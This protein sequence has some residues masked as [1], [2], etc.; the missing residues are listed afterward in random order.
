MFNQVLDPNYF[1]NFSKGHFPELLG[2]VIKQVEEGKMIAEMP[3]KKTLFAPN[4]FLHA[5]SIVAFADT[6]AGY[7][8]IAHLPEKGK[9]FTTLELKSNFTGAI[10]EGNLECECSAEH[11]GRTTQVWRVIIRNQQTKKKT[12]VFSCTQLILY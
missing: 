1:N 2:I 5:G 11:L 8:T 7:C 10:R 3:V 4:G 9:S 12:A 6:V